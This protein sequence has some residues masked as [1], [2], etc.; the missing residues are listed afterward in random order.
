MTTHQTNPF[1]SP[2]ADY[3]VLVNAENQHSLWPVFADIPRG[4]TPTFGPDRRD[5]CLEFVDR[6][7]TDITPSSLL[8]EGTD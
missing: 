6:N 5:A 3:L 7:W 1:E 4:W 2:D 8:P